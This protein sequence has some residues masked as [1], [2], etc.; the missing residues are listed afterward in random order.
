ML[1]YSHHPLYINSSTHRILHYEVNWR[2]YFCSY[3]SQTQSPNPMIRKSVALSL[4]L[5]AYNVS[6]V[7]ILQLCGVIHTDLKQAEA[8]SLT[9]CILFGPQVPTM[10]NTHRCK[11]VQSPEAMLQ[12]QE[13]ESFDFKTRFIGVPQKKQL[14]LQCIDLIPVLYG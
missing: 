4:W 10:K 9:F 14:L 5:M 12:S 1:M 2:K 7:T 8:C 13:H 6:S 11:F 3:M